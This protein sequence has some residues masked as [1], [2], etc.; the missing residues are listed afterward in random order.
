MRFVLVAG[1]S[2]QGF[3]GTLKYREACGQVFPH[4]TYSAR[5]IQLIH[6]GTPSRSSS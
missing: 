5:F 2:G 1:Q 4:V 3:D 6:L